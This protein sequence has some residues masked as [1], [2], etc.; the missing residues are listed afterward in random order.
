M[1]KENRLVDIE[2]YITYLNY[3]YLNQVDSNCK[4]PITILG[5]SQ[6]AAT[7]SRWVSTGESAIRQ[8]HLMVWSLSI[9]HEFR[10]RAR[11]AAG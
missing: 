6:G 8:A 7:A 2:N 9:R 1:T 4:V 11:V 5:F 3:L 10:I